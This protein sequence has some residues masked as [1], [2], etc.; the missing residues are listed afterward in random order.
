MLRVSSDKPEC[1]ASMLGVAEEH[2]L[3]ALRAVATDLLLANWGAAK[4]AGVLDDLPP[5]LV[6]GL[7]GEAVA[8]CDRYEAVLRQFARR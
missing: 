3:A 2:G 5:G 7:A 4:A 8:R 6:E 1:A